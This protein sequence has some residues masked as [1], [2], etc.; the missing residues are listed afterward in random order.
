MA[1]YSDFVTAAK[2]AQDPTTS[3][4][5]LTQIAA[6]QPTLRPLVAAN[7]SADSSLVDWL[8]S[9]PDNFTKAAAAARRSTEAGQ[10]FG[11]GAAKL[12]SWIVPV[13]VAVAVVAAAA[14]LVVGHF[15]WTPSSPT[16]SGGPGSASSSG[17]SSNL[18]YTGPLAAPQVAPP[19]GNSKDVTLSAWITVPGGTPKSGAL[20]VDIHFDYQCPYCDIL[21]K[22]YDQAFADLAASGDIILRYHTRTFLDRLTINDSSSLA[23]MAAACVDI[24]DNTKYV[25]YHNTIFANQPKE[26]TGYT[27]Q[28][29]RSDFANTAG[30]T[31]NA[32]AT[33]Q[34]CYD[35]RATRD[36]V[37]YSEPNNSSLIQNPN[38]PA[39][40]LFG[41][42]APLYYDKT[43]G[44]MT[45]DTVNGQASGVS[46]TPMILVNGSAISWSGLFDS[47]FNPTTPQTAAG[48][49]SYLQQSASQ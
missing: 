25:A 16:S 26:G 17:T 49:L 21:E 20:I 47:N 33:F 40:Y 14:G 32:L 48:L 22:G 31:G 4:G 45:N 41:G 42:N 43:T 28:Q 44:Q 37:A 35:R 34:A 27:D 19:D 7:P 3:S 2:A 38:P 5:D 9:Q 12:A 46:G 18:G 6:A 36:W 29:L 1:D 15:A 13:I 8:G 39:T 10:P 30:L 23:A 24:A 11:V